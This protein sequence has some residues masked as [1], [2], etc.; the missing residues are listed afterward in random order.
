MPIIVDEQFAILQLCSH[1]GGVLVLLLNLLLNI[2][3]CESVILPSEVLKM[4][5]NFIVK[6]SFRHTADT[7]SLQSPQN[8]MTK[9]ATHM[10]KTSVLFGR[11]PHCFTRRCTVHIAAPLLFMTLFLLSPPNNLKPPFSASLDTVAIS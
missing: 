10:C 11:I 8:Y 3:A 6:Q 9:H 4:F 2:Y 7:L 1:A 5:R